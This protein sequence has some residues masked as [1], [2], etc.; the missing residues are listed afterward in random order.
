[1]KEHSDGYRSI[2]YITK[3]NF[4]KATVRCEL[5]VRTIFEEG[6]SEIDHKVRYP[7]FTDDPLIRDFLHVFNR[8]SGAADEM[9]TF[10]NRLATD[11][12]ALTAEQ[13][14]AQAR[15]QDI[16]R[17]LTEKI[18]KIESLSSKNSSMTSEMRDLKKLI[19]RQKDEAKQ[20]NGS[21]LNSLGN[22]RLGKIDPSGILVTSDALRS[23]N[24]SP[25][26]F[27]DAVS[28]SRVMIDAGKIT[29]AS[30]NFVPG[31]TVDFKDE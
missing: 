29:A 7:D 21:N 14:R 25:S 15:A 9:G 22:I 27:S 16:E 18:K 19:E 2:H 20:T 31:K 26:Q 12:A 13:A 24:I 5:Q 3:T 4:T 23:L 6:W 30:L 10:V 8:L 28:A 11:L 1:M 17:Q